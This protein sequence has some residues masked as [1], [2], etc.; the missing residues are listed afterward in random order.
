MPL[1][2][3]SALHG[4]DFAPLKLAGPGPGQDERPH[5]GAVNPGRRRRHAV[6]GF[7]DER[8]L[9]PAHVKR[10]ADG[11]EAPFR[12]MDGRPFRLGGAGN[13]DEAVQCIRRRGEACGDAVA[14]AAYVAA[15]ATRHK[16][17][18]TFVQKLAGLA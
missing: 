5:Q 4:F 6:S 12:R 1:A 14:Q 10:Q 8:A 18:R 3:A 13:Y 2:R 11:H 15:L 9:P 7:E 17:K 16:A